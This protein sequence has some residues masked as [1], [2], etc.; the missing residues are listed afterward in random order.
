[1]D[2]IGLYLSSA[3]ERL[4]TAREDVV[5]QFSIGF[6][7]ETEIEWSRVVRTTLGLRGDVYH[8]DVQSDNPLNSGTASAGVAS[9]K[10]TAVFGPWGG[11]EFYANWGLGFHSNSGLGATLSVDPLTGAPAERSTPVVRSHG[12]EFGV[13]TVAVPGLQTT[14]TFW[15]LGFGSEL[16]FVGDSGSTEAGPPSRRFGLEVTNYFSPHPWLTL[17]MDVSFSRARFVDVPAGEAFVPGA[18]NRVLAG[19]LTVEPPEDRTG[20]VGSI[21]L[22]HFGPRP[23]LEDNSVNSRSTSLVNG[24]IGYKFSP[25]VRL[26]LEGFNLFDAEASDIEY[27][28][29]SRLPGEPAEGVAD[30]HLHPAL[31]RMARVALRF[32][33]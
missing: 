12:S 2:P 26:V 3:G 18:L 5:S 30:I 28:Y 21:R 8:Y 33:L 27:F 7:G 25:R 31:P 15:Y 4:S 1:V 22:R 10:V 29:E 23:L 9:P 16:V 6:F 17:D 32:T 11:T 24:E 19:G 13:R 14:A 20:P